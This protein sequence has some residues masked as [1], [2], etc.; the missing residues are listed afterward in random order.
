MIDIA[1]ED[2][3]WRKD[4]VIK[5]PKSIQEEKNEKVNAMQSIQDKNMLP[6]TFLYE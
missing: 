6:N 2:K 3:F 1:M 4:I 5:S